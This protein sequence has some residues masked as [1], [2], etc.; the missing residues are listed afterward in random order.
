MRCTPQISRETRRTSRPNAQR[1][2]L[3]PI[4]NAP[5]NPSPTLKLSKPASPVCVTQRAEA[6]SGRPGPSFSARVTGY[7][8]NEMGLQELNGKLSRS[9]PPRPVEC[10]N[11]QPATPFPASCQTLAR[12]KRA[13]SGDGSGWGRVVINVVG[14]M[15]GKVFDLCWNTAFR[16]L[17]TAD[18][19][20]YKIE[21]EASVPIAWS[22]GLAFEEMKYDHIQEHRRDLVRNLSPVPGHFPEE[23]FI[24]DYM[25]HPQ[26][27]QLA[28]L[29]STDSQETLKK[30]SNQGRESVEVS[31]SDKMRPEAP[32]VLNNLYPK[33]DNLSSHTLQPRNTLHRSRV[34]IAGSPGPRG[35]RPASYASPRGSPRRSCANASQLSPR[36]QTGCQSL[37]SSTASPRRKRSYEPKQSI[38]NPVS[39]DI[40]RFEKR[41]RRHER[42]EDEDMQRLNQQLRDMIKQG[43][44]ALRTTVEVE[45]GSED[46]NE[47]G[48]EEE[49]HFANA[50]G[51]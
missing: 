35:D 40:Q 47:L 21:S 8:E 18:G 39:P 9:S 2:P 25:S 6:S 41:R 44:Q 26:D 23:G 36:R 17:Q 12:R 27:H 15:V 32:N 7:K 34:S 31:G 22:S 29:R 10:V 14:G 19:Q 11:P 28:E 43:K 20:A 48:R 5:D 30:K 46:D 33:L 1:P 3:Q 4:R 38:S 24:T 45:Y 49:L 37:Q 42:K 16:G 13:Y 50:F 51:G